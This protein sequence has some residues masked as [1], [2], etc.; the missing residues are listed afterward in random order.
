MSN[1]TEAHDVLTRKRLNHGS[2]G[3]VVVVVGHHQ[4]LAENGEQGRTSLTKQP[5][6]GEQSASPATTP[7]IPSSTYQELRLLLELAVPTI[8][9]QL[10][11]TIPPFLTASYVGRTFGAIALD[12]FQLANLICNLFTLSLLSGLYSASDTLSPQAYGAG[13][14]REVGLVAIRGFL[15]SLLVVVPACLLILLTMERGL[16]WFGEDVQASYYAYHWYR[17]YALSLPFYVL[18]MVTWK[19]LSAQGVM[20]PLLI[21]STVS[22]FGVLP[23]ALQFLTRWLGF[24]GSA[25]ALLLFQMSQTSI[26]MGLV[27]WQRP[28]RPETWPGLHA[29]V[30]REVLHWK[31]FKYFFYL[32]M[33]GMMASSEWIY[34]ETL[35][36]PCIYR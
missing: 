9:I 6:P 30:W 11:F 24:P 28:Y 3:V 21:A 20:G 2:A 16:I 1:D 32:G 5:K 15:S 12:G 36:V 33:G 14:Y 17:I 18:Y 8:W 4:P 22:C 25:A 26:A 10:G 29:D 35:C 27:L 23:L 7:S 13:N 34:W 31:A 19:F